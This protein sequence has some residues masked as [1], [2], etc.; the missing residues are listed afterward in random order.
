MAEGPAISVM[1]PTYNG[2]EYLLEAV[3]SVLDDLREDD[4]LLIQDAGS[5]DGS[6]ERVLDLAVGRPQV[7]VVSA[8]AKN[9]ISAET[10]MP[11][12]GASAAGYARG[13]DSGSSAGFEA[14]SAMIRAD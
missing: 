9:D 14:E 11:R 5:T 7:K 4:E 2:G 13:T 3:A 10:E 8:P 6:I 1:V 12:V